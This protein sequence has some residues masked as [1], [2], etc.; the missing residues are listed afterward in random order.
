MSPY[1]IVM[2]IATALGLLFGAMAEHALIGGIIGF[3]VGAVLC[4]VGTGNYTD[5][6]SDGDD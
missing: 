6:Y 5:F 1:A 3:V 2:I 4:V